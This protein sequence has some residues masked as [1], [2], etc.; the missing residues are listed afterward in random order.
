[1]TSPP[2]ETKA[3]LIDESNWEGQIKGDWENL[4]LPY[5]EKHGVKSIGTLGTILG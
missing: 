2:E 3:F 4:I 5:A 1:M